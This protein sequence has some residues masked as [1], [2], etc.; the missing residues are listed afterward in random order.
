MW[1]EEPCLRAKAEF[2]K[3]AGVRGELNREMPTTTP[4]SSMMVREMS[5]S[6]YERINNSFFPQNFPSHFSGQNL[7]LSLL[8]NWWSMFYGSSYP[9]ME[10]CKLPKC[11][12][13]K[14]IG[15]PPWQLS[16]K[17]PSA[18]LFSGWSRIAA[19]G[20][21]PWCSLRITTR[22]CCGPPRTT[23]SI[24]LDERSKH[25]TRFRRILC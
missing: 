8:Q 2:I 4:W 15:T 17:N 23:I 22:S 14:C 18:R 11:Q 19:L 10:K 6:G 13:P 5:R 20:S 24:L 7:R 9:V 1:R 12:R 25:V 3:Q 16:S 21:R